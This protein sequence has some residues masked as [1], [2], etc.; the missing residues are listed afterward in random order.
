[1]Q[2]PKSMTIK[3]LLASSLFVLPFLLSTCSDKSVNNFDNQPTSLEQSRIY[4][5]W[6]YDGELERLY[7]RFTDQMKNALTLEELDTARSQL[8]DF[9]GEETEIID[10]NVTVISAEAL[11]ERVA[12]FEN[13]DTPV[14]IQLLLNALR[15]INGFNINVLPEEAESVYLD[16][17]TQA[18]LRLPFDD[19]WYVVWG[20]RNVYENY[21]AVYSDQRFATDFLIRENGSSYVGK[22]TRNESYYSFDQPIYAPAAGIIIASANDVA[23][24]IPGVMNPQQPLGNHVIIDHGN[25]EYSFMAH[26][27]QASLVVWTGDTVIAGQLLGK[28]GNS[29]NSSE[30]HLHYHLQ[31]T[32]EFNAG[33]GLPAFFNNYN[34]DGVPVERGEPQ[35]RQTVEKQ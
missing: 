21:H 22:G 25:S 8:M 15:N 27:K 31:N 9:L 16:Y 34:A 14:R 29:G 20:G 18:E 7:G 13:S 10:E 24:N 26:F 28:C 35:R 33:E 12:L 4:L 11:Y 1:M 6:F 19:A 17:E 5:Q 2:I 23:D 30:P 32:A 3:I